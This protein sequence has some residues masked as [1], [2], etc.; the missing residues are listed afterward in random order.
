MQPQIKQ[1]GVN[2]LDGT[3]DI[4]TLHEKFYDGFLSSRSAR[5]DLPDW[6]KEED[7]ED[8]RERLHTHRYDEYVQGEMAA[9]LSSLKADDQE[10]VGSETV[11]EKYVE[12]KNEF[13]D[14]NPDVEPQMF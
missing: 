14:E 8:Y 9:W 11:Q 2:G 3:C 1:E 7:E 6:L 4:R 5:K 12:F 10:T 13:L